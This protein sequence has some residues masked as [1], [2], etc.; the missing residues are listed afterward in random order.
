M[1]INRKIKSLLITTTIIFSIIGLAIAR[2]SDFDDFSGEG[3]SSCHGN[4]TQSASG[5][6]TISSSSGTSIIPNEVFTVSI[7]IFSFAEAQGSNI[8]VGFPSGSPGKGDNKD[9]TFDATQKSVSIDG[10]GNSVTIDFQ[11]TAPSTEQSYTLHADAIYRA[12]GS[13]SY[14]SHGDF[15]LTVE[16][17]NTPPQFSNI[18]ESADPLELGQEETFSV[19][20]TDTET[21]VSSVLIEL[22]STNYTMSN[23]IGNTYKY[24]WTP[25]TTGL[26]AYVIYANDT[27]GVWN[28]TNGNLSIIDTTPPNI[29]NLSES[30]DPLELGQTETIQ[31]DAIDLSSI[32]QV[33]IEINSLNFTMTNIIG[34]TW[35]YSNWVPTSTGIKS[36]TIHAN[37][38]EGN[39]NSLGDSILVQDTVQP[40]L[41]GLTESSD[42]L[43]LGQTELIQ[44]NATDLSGI[45][46]VLIEIAAAN[47]TMINAGGSLWEYNS[48]IPTTTG[49]KAY[50]I[51]AN[52]TKNNWN[53]LTNSILVQDTTPP[54]V[55]LLSESSDPLELGQA[56]TIQINATDLSGIS[57]VLIEIDSLNYTMA[58][59]IGSTWEY[60]N[61]VPTST[62]I[63]SYTIHANDTKGNWNSISGDITVK[64]TFQP[65]LLNLIESSDPIELGQTETIQINATDLSGISQVLIEI[66]SLNYT[67]TNTIGSTWEY[68]NWVPTTIGIKSYTIHAN[69][70]E[71]NW[72]SI[73]GDITVIDTISPKFNYLIESA[74][75][76]PLGQNETIS[77]EVYD[78]PGSGVKSVFLEYDNINHTMSFIGL[79][80]W[81]WSNWK[82]ISVGIFNYSIYMIDNSDN[83]NMTF[84]TI[85]VII[86]TGP[87]IQ[88]L[89][90][91]ADP[92]ELGQ[93]ETIQVDVSDTDGVS[94]AFIE[95]GDFNYT[96]ANVG[97]IRYGYAWTPDTVGTKLFKIYANDSLNNWNQI[98]DSVLVQDTTSP[99][100]GNLTESS[101]PL[102][103][104]NAIT[105]SIDA[106]DLSGINQVLFQFEGTNYTM[107]NIGGNTWFNDTWIPNIVNTYPYFIY[108]QDKSNNWNMTSGSLDVIDTISPLLINL[109]ENNDPLELGQT[110]V[111][112]IDI[113]DLAPISSVLIEINGINY[114][115]INVIGSTWEY[116]SWVPTTTGIKSYTIYANDTSNNKISFI[117]NIT[118]VDTNG[119]MLSNLLESAD[120]LEFSETEIIRINATDLS[121]ISHLVIEINDVNYTMSNIGISTWEYN[122]WTPTSVGFK[123][124]TIY[125][126]DTEGNWN[127]LDAGI[128]VEDTLGPILTA[129]SENAD[130]L[131]LGQT[132]T[133]GINIIDISGI[134]QVRIEIGGFNYTMINIGGSVWEYD[135]WTPTSTGLKSYTIYAKDTEGNLNSLTS[136]I[137]VQDTIK[138]LLSN[139]LENTD[140]LELGQTEIV[141]INATDLSGINQVLIEINGGNYTMVNI[142]GMTW[143]HNIW[144]PST[145]GIKNYVIYTQD[146]NGN[147]NSLSSNITVV[148]TVAPTLTNLIEL[149]DP[150]ELGTLPL[151]QV[152]IIDHSPITLVILESKDVN[153]TMTFIGGITW[154]SNTWAPS[155]TGLKTYTIFAFDSSNNMV[156]LQNN[157]TIIDTLGPV[158]N[159]LMKSDES[160]FLGQSVTI[161]IEVTDF[162]GV[163]EVFIEFEGSNHTMVNNFGDN[164]EFSN[165]IP[166]IAGELSFTIHAKDNNNIWNSKLGTISVIELSTEI[167]TINMKE[168]TDIL[169]FSGMIAVT[170]IGIVLIAKTTKRKR[171]FH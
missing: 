49:L 123:L 138:P 89:S 143:Q 54:N 90:K 11:V 3:H 17:Q 147:W 100:F 27:N 34:S 58:N 154:R 167:N 107:S 159:N 44:I 63:K 119:P 117:S 47:Y 45:S 1:R 124:Y 129:L 33:L 161:Q 79:D 94:N 128:L 74:D 30:A 21:S 118:V 14:F 153:Y 9:F 81:R 83:L 82:P 99:N 75:P 163:S 78:S 91:S 166:S 105:V 23:T 93:L 84:G 71:G 160:I 87:T 152:D 42:P 150:L 24:K 51:Y 130:P 170:V 103:L 70:T 149:T 104:G 48:W 5:Y 13:S 113:I 65:S 68:S 109:N 2:T 22:E 142:G 16:M 131:E 144:V 164:W 116:N 64:D 146:S 125:A 137:T 6:V 134:S 8:A 158:F 151:I 12:S 95:I 4:I 52:D 43:E 88:N 98:S 7:Q 139:L 69:D 26:K 126:N 97:G 127:S 102:E 39:L 108:I 76:L 10:S 38:T 25:S 61:W 73:G 111:I 110:E 66:D 15:I 50:T 155:N 121:G 101:N 28:S 62:G 60:S 18:I 165:L 53:S 32:S 19:D 46:Q 135:S 77:L 168:I 55:F 31:I 35:E 67:M 114:T 92:L 80:T 136:S 40:S 96:M 72:N 140:P 171:F 133:I 106:A 162:S 112:Q 56:E 169:V 148:D 20:V 37:D 132:E 86:S 145:I 57:Q 115:M 122:N 36:Y 59:T 29:S 157:I 141:Y 85:E 41:T 120:P 156:T